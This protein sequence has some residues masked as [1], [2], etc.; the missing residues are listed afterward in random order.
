MKT[1]RVRVRKGRKYIEVIRSGDGKR[2][3][4]VARR[5]VDTLALV[6]QVLRN[7]GCAEAAAQVSA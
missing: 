6:V 5:D 1:N 7:E 2:L 4:R 3:I